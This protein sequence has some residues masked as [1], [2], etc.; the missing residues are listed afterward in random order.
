MS[1][2]H[3]KKLTIGPADTDLFQ[4]LRPSSLLQMLQ[5]LAT[6]HA[7]ILGVS[8]EVLIQRHNSIW[9]LVRLWYS[10]KRPIG[11]HEQ[12]TIRTWH[13]G[14]KSAT[15]HRDFD[16]FS[17]NEW[18]G[19]SVTSWVIADADCRK[20]LRPSTVREMADS[21]FPENVKEK[22]LTKMRL[23]ANWTDAGTRRVYYSDTDIN[24]H[25]NNKRYID[26]ACDS[27][28]YD[29]MRGVFVQEAE[30]NY[31]AE[32]FSG[33]ELIIMKSERDGIHYIQGSDK[34]AKVRFDVSLKFGE[35]VTQ[36]LLDK[37]RRI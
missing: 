34:N 24:G 2:I 12:I 10:L 29:Q 11:A 7:D 17:G 33:E 5:E 14:A 18:V 1:A 28:R 35:I 26:I 9:M 4:Q 21:P 37:Q 15:I 22:T 16:I 6:E 13:R 8:R 32:C 19:E 20:M 36:R 27:L 31:V 3:E 30:V 23:P 25:M